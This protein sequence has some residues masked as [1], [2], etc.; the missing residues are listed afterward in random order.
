MV[1][2]VFDEVHETGISTGDGFI[3]MLHEMDTIWI[4]GKLYRRS[5]IDISQY[6]ND[7]MRNIYMGDKLNGIIPYMSIFEF[8]NKLKAE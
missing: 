8:L 2:G 3:L 1:A 6:Y 7:I 4:F 5:F